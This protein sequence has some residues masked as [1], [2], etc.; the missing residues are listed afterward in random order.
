MV[1]AED[2]EAEEQEEGQVEVVASPASAVE[3]L[4][5]RH[6]HAHKGVIVR[7]LVIQKKNFIE[8]PF[9]NIH[10]LTH[11]LNIMSNLKRFD[12]RFSRLA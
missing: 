5:T 6:L 4:D 3:E 10:W 8:R 12:M 7:V 9:L 2:Q 11:H 1:E